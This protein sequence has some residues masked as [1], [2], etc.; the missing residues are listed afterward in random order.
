MRGHAHYFQGFA[1]N[2]EI[3]DWVADDAVWCELLSTFKFPD[4]QGKYREFCGF[5]SSWGRSKAENSFVRFM[6]LTKFPVQKEQGIHFGEQGMILKD[7]GIF[8]P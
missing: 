3:V 1:E 4:H 5:G 7:Q 6:N 8:R 2:A